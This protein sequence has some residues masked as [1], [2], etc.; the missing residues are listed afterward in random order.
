MSVRGFSVGAASVVGSFVVYG[1]H[2]ACGGPGMRVVGPSVAQTVSA[3][4]SASSSE[5]PPSPP[6]ST[7]CACVGPRLNAF[8]TVS[9]DEKMTLDPTDAEARLDVS[10][11]RSSAGK[12]L[13]VLSGTVRA[14]RTDVANEHPTTLA[15]RIVHPDGPSSSSGFKDAVTKEIEANVTTWGGSVVAPRVY[16]VVAKSALSITVTDSAVEI[17]GSLTLRDPPT[18][19]AITLEKLVIKK[20]GTSLLPDRTSTFHP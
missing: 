18:N 20:T 3:S 8:F 19:R 6:P 5:A 14:Y 2:V 7:G 12:K 9:G 13:I 4:A 16:A 10:Y 17:R 11:A 15:I 1:A